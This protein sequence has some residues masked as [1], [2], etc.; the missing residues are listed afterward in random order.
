MG[1]CSYVLT[2]TEHGM[3]ETFGSTC[4]GAVSIL[5]NGKGCLFNCCVDLLL[6]PGSLHGGPTSFNLFRPLNE[7]SPSII[8]CSLPLSAVHLSTSLLTLS[9]HRN[10]SLPLLLLPPSSIVCAG[11]NKFCAFCLCIT[12]VQPFCVCITYVQPFCVCITYV[13]PFHCE[14][15]ASPSKIL[16]LVGTSPCV[17]GYFAMSR[18]GTLP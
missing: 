2:G 16:V 13:Q 5:P 14:L 6:P 12:Y 17:V 15:F 4:H 8:C 10:F 9:L 3:Q 11:R 7:S 18:V 1:T